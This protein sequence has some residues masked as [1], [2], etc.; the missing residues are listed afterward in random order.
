MKKHLF[1]LLISLFLASVGLAA[2]FLGSDAMLV[3]E[4]R[5]PAS[6]PSFSL[7]SG[8][9]S[10]Q[11]ESY[12][13]DR[14]PL[15]AFLT[16]TDALRKRLSGAGIDEEILSFGGALNERPLRIDARLQKNLD[17]L[18]R[19]SRESGMEIVLLTP[20]TAGYVRARSG[21]APLAYPDEEIFAAI[22]GTEGLTSVP[23]LEAFD[24]GELYYRTD[25]H[26]NA[27]GAYLA[28]SLV[29]PYLGLEARSR[30]A[31]EVSSFPVFRGSCYNRAMLWHIQ[32]EDIMLWD[33]KNPYAVTLDGNTDHEGIF[34]TEHL[35][36]ADPYQVYLD[37][38][39][40]LTVIDNP[41]GSG[42]SLLI[43]KDSFGNSVAP[44]LAG[45]YSRVTLIDLRAYRGHISELGQF[46]RVLAVY[47]PD[48]LVTATSLSY[49]HY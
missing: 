7:E 28:Y 47:C 2:L 40:G 43:L 44:L 45:H 8:K 34:F 5:Y 6:A 12:L 31:V 29:C 32:A 19:F 42:R 46:D 9:M 24:S 49:L 26:W 22:A 27:D 30:D 1:P 18:S 33:D 25:P 3:L 39:H 13:S 41:E 20:P 21:G 37:G 10:E 11:T 23:T 4:K 17:L 14:L 16:E 38:N 48:S 36:G 15:R 35:E